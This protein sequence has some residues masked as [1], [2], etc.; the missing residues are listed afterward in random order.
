MN[1][2][3]TLTKTLP[4]LVGQHE[5]LCQVRPA[6]GNR[7]TDK[8]TYHLL[9]VRLY[10]Y[11]HESTNLICCM[12]SETWNFRITF[13]RFFWNATSKK[14][15]KSH[16]FGFSKKRKTVFSNYAWPIR[17]RVG[18]VETPVIFIKMVRMRRRDSMFATPFP[19]RRSRWRC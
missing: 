3:L 19:I 10:T 5:S 14:N 4:G 1:L 8:Q 12:Y 11:I 16:V 17:E 9:Y 13:F 7:Q 6:S 15:V 18:S 2:T